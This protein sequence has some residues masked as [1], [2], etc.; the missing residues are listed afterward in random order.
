[1]RQYELRFPE[2]IAGF[3]AEYYNALEII[4]EDYMDERPHRKSSERQ[5][6][7]CLFFIC[8]QQTCNLSESLPYKEGLTF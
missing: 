3:E 1:M 6:K 8:L 4:R 2:K 5:I 7:F